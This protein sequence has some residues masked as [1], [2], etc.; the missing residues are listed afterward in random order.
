MTKISTIKELGVLMSETLSNSLFYDTIMILVINILKL[1]DLYQH[2]PWVKVWCCFVFHWNQSFQKVSEGFSRVCIF[3]LNLCRPFPVSSTFSQA[4][5]FTRW[6]CSVIASSDWIS[7]YRLCCP[8]PSN[9]SLTIYLPLLVLHCSKFMASSFHH[10]T[11]VT[12]D[13]LL[14]NKTISPV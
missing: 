9:C 1:K 5:K 4:L 14:S 12:S 10:V 11:H 8:S 6:H 2:L 7:F 13:C 3:L